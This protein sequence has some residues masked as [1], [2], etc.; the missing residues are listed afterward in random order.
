MEEIALKTKTKQDC[1]VEELHWDLQRWKSE[2]QFLD[3]EAI[4]IKRLLNSY[5][6]EPN[7]PNLFERIEIFKKRLE[8][9]NSEKI[10]ITNRISKHESD[11]AGMLECMNVSCDQW[12]YQKHEILQLKVNEFITKF[13]ALKSSIFNYAGGILRKHKP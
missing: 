7:T 9:V 11:L 1:K 2:I 3:D 8:K 12:Y 4:F 10:E 6:F 13:G 5:V